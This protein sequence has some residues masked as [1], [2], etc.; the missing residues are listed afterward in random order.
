MGNRQ[1][2]RYHV[3][4]RTTSFLDCLGNGTDLKGIP[5]LLRHSRVKLQLAVQS[6][7]PCASFKFPFFVF[8]LTT[9]SLRAHPLA[10]T[11]RRRKWGAFPQNSLHGRRASERKRRGTEFGL[12]DVGTLAARL[13]GLSRFTDRLP[14][15]HQRWLGCAFTRQNGSLRDRLSDVVQRWLPVHGNF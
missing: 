11:G 4:L 13:C 6:S 14:P 3:N 12:G 15:I 9:L 10:T 5:Y 8:W 7:P 2:A 1:Q